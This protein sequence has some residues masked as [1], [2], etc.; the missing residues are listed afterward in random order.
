M[1]TVLVAARNYTVETLVPTGL[2]AALSGLTDYEI[3]NTE[4]LKLNENVTDL[5]G[6]DRFP[7]L[8]AL[9]LTGAT[10]LT[11]VDL[12]RNET[13]LSLDISGNASI[14]VFNITGSKYH[15]KQNRKCLCPKLCKS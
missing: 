8:T 5:S 1:I 3:E 15:R 10:L 13:V 9:D 4:T 11:S 7:N 12:R 6:I 14:T 2:S